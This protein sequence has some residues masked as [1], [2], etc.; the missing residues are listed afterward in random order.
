MGDNSGLEREIEE[1]KQMREEM[2]IRWLER[3]SLWSG[4]M[5]WVDLG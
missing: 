5:K 1:V 4:E 2:G 3:E